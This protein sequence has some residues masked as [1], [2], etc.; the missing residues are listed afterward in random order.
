[1]SSSPSLL[2]VHVAEV[3]V[4][5]IA[6]EKQDKLGPHTCGS[7]HWISTTCGPLY[8]METRWISTTCGPLYQMDLLWSSSFFDME[9]QNGLARRAVQ[10]TTREA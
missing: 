9:R 3:V 8:H 4:I 1:M 7:V 10:S 6:T 2:L 5:F